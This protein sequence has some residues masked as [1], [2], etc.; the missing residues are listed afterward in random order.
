M[1]AAVTLAMEGRR[2]LVIEGADRIGGGCRTAELTLPGFHHDVC[3]AAFPLAVGSPF[4][5]RLPLERYG[6]R[7]IEPEVAV[8]H[9]LDPQRAAI[10]HRRLDLTEAGLGVDGEAY[11]R[12]ME[13][14]VESWDEI[15][16]HLLGPL[17]RI[18]HRPIALARFGRVAVRSA[19]GLVR[20][21]FRSPEA[22]ALLGGCAAHSFLPLTHPTTAAFAVLYP[23]LAHRH[24]WP[25]AA[26]GA[27][28]LADSLAAY[29]R[30]LGGEIETGRW[31]RSLSELPPTRAVLL[32]VTPRQLVDMVDLPSPYRK[33][34]LG[35]RFGPAAFKVDFA[36]DGP[37]PWQHPDLPA[38]GTVHLGGTLEEVARAEADAWGGR[39]SAFPFVLVSQPSALDPTRAPAGKHAVW[40]YA[41]VPHGT[42]ADYLEVIESQIERFA[43]GF[44]ERILARH[45]IDPV[46]WPEYNPNHVGGDITGGAH[47]LRQLLF[48][49]FPKRDPYATPV[50]GVYLCSSSTPP[51][52][53]V[54]G[55]CGYWAA[56]RA[57]DGPLG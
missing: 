22:R 18:P 52:A 42:D 56:R 47:T 51:G 38:A 44:R 21:S 24:G 26:G 23:I 43:P 7:W 33:R 14:L 36:L 11:R 30:D 3:S 41:H 53:G 40:A 4:F 31:V 57:L 35:Y 27:Q 50:P 49:P 17:I 48:R 20:S 8:A 55:M 9:P 2:V 34:A 32:D 19:M 10:L 16:D 45:V 29:L 28:A 37:I 46:R 5:R 25:I 1:A 6:L 13:P 54:H 39:V 12:L 15:E